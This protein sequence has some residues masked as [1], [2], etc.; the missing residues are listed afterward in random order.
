MEVTPLFSSLPTRFPTLLAFFSSTSKLDIVYTAPFPAAFGQNMQRFSTALRATRL[1]A[2]RDFLL[3]SWWVF[4]FALFCFCIHLF[5]SHEHKR[6]IACL[7]RLKMS[8]QLKREHWSQQ[9]NIWQTQ[10]LNCTNTLWLELVLMR[11]LGVCPKGTI[12]AVF[13]EIDPVICPF[14]GKDL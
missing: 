4:S 10:Q 2:L 3:G 13:R 14:K 12:K 8:Y 5:A 7:E 6:H 9:Q 1:I 11:E